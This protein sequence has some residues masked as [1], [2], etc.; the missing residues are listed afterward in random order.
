MYNKLIFIDVKPQQTD[1]RQNQAIVRGE[2][3]LEIA[4]QTEMQEMRIN[5]PG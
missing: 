3:A 4:K 2:Q 1:A 5:G